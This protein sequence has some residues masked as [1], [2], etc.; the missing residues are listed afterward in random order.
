MSS[1]SSSPQN[2]L[3]Q[4]GEDFVAKWLEKQGWIILQR[5]WHCRWGEL[6][7]VAQFPLQRQVR[8]HFNQPVQS[9]ESDQSTT[10][11][12]FVEVKTRSQGS[13]D[14]NGLQSITPAKQQKLWQAAHL[15]LADYPDLATLPCRFDVALV[16]HQRFQSSQSRPVPT[17]KWVAP[18]PQIGYTLVLQDYIPSAFELSEGN[19]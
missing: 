17:P 2:D 18:S 13:W 3:G 9:C 14:A 19:A 8:S 1:A 6:D 11:I 7:L 12:A 15:F 4:W 5:R 10:G 16:Y